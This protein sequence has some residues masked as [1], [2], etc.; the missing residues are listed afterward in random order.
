M[1][2]AYIAVMT[3]AYAVSHL[4]SEHGVKANCGVETSFTVSTSVTNDCINN[5]DS[6]TSGWADQSP[7][8]HAGDY[9]CYCNAGF[10]ATAGDNGATCAY[11]D[12]CADSL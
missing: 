6:V 10:R 1:N 8:V 9:S 4:G 12:E 2:R 5:P 3:A 11:V 7:G